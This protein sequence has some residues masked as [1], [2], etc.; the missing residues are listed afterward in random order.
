VLRRLAAWLATGP[1]GH[2]AAGVADWVE[3]LAR[4]G[5]SKRR[6]RDRPLIDTRRRG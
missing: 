3:L 5:W 1:L 6:R 4:W 2:L